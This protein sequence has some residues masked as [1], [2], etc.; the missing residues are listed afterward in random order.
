MIDHVSIRSDDSYT[1]WDTFHIRRV[2]CAIKCLDN[3]DMTPEQRQEI[4]DRE[5]E[6]MKMVDQKDTEA[7][8][9]E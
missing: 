4:I 7:R 3:P 2:I 6:I 5:I 9:Q 1:A 8:Q